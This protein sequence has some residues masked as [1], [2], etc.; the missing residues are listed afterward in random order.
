M[1]YNY[2]VFDAKKKIQK[3]V[4]DAPT[5]RD[6]T[7]LLINQGWYIKKISPFGPLSLNLSFGS[8]A[9]LVDKVL[10]TKHLSTMIKSGISLTESLEVIAEQTGSKKFREIIEKM[11]EKIKAGQSLSTSMTAFP[12]VFDPMIVNIVNIGESS[13]T[14]EENLQY[15]AESL[16]D[17]MDL[18]RNIKSATLYPGIVLSATFVLCIVLAY[19][20]LPTIGKLFKSFSFKLPLPTRILMGASDIMEKHGVI[21][22]VGIVIFIFAFITLIKQKFFKPYWHR[23]LLSFPVV[24][25]VIKN[26][27]LVLVSRTLGML[28]KSGLPIDQGMKIISQTTSNVI[29]SRSLVK[30]QAQIE[31]GKK[32][33]DV[34][35]NLPQS[36]RNPLFPLLVVK[37]I[38]VGERTGK[39]DESLLYLAEFYQKEVDN[40]A[41]NLA[42]ALEPV[43]LIFIALV[44]GFIAVSVIMPI[45]QITGQMK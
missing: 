34:L 27:N 31:K 20:V 22:I 5:L 23:F 32:L 17:R 14:L 40:D 37:M 18:K 19:F 7:K 30:A 39:L 25:K 8:G 36:K 42:V 15:L 35:A 28:L 12:K 21:I 1:K 16:E 41:K 13:G 45:Y 11:S 6:A 4:I 24:G 3:G 9:S 26:Y 29:Y 43:L 2:V 44:V 33:S 38:S 10:F